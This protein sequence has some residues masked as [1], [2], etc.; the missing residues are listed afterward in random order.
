MPAPRF[1]AGF[2]TQHATQ[3][4][5]ASG[6]V[7][8]FEV[9]SDHF[10]GVGGKR[11]ALV[12][13]LRADFPLALH[14]VSL[15]IAGPD[16]L[17]SEYLDELRE[18]ADRLEPLWVSDHLCWTSLDGHHSHDLLPIAHT[19][20]VL[21]HVCAR[22]QQVQ[23]RLRRP[24]VLENATAY[25]AFR[26]SERGEA[27]FFA[28]LCR[29]TG[30]AMLL[31]VNNLYVNAQN[32]G[33]EPDA[34]LAALPERAIAYMHVAGHAVLPDVRIDTHDAEVPA[35]VWEL[36]ERAVRR[37]PEASVIVER[38]DNIPPFEELAREVE[39]ARGRHRAAVALPNAPLAQAPE[40][41]AA[42]SAP[43]RWAATARE[44]FLRIV[45]KPLGFDHGAAGS[46]ASL[47]E[48][49]LP[50]RASRGIRVY[51]DAYTASLRRALATNF[52][53]LARVIGRDDLERLAAAYLRAHPPGRHD[54]RTLGAELAAF[55]RSHEFAHDYGVTREV[56]AELVALEQ[57][58]LEV[59][60]EV[61]G[62]A[63]EIPAERLRQIDP[64][65]WEQAR[66][67][68]SGAIRVVH[69]THDVLP[70]V[71][72]VARG[73]TPERPAPGP[74]G[75]LVH[76]TGDGDVRC[77]RLAPHEARLLEALL[78]G[79]SFGDAIA[80]AGRTAPLD[81]ARL[82]ADGA[83]VLAQAAHLGLLTRIE[84]SAD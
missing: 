48:D 72:A 51:S 50:V 74:A 71:E 5:Q 80:E 73:E 77:E 22:V 84:I 58:Q 9:L 82:A 52:A 53:A 63:K 24:L 39:H 66:F 79:R 65:R 40:R 23:D 13:R 62:G 69:A 28:E 70:V 19:Q 26:S 33:V 34:Y 20:E 83:R 47:L 57:A 42:G 31:D 60:D 68:F 3:I 16:P 1:G 18:L 64:S 61:D 46:L 4:A 14:G 7:E 36:F 6:R 11:R 59:Q 30:C 44:F 37:F 8:W 21:D 41:G 35:P 15:G 2:R 27:E 45:D 12:D 81:L 54:F 32:L 56:F 76:R 75:Y 67:G 49:G 78:A 43:G 38:D 17:R 25:V 10:I 55:V 29:R